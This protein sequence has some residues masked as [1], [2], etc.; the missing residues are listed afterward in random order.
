LTKHRYLLDTNIASCV[1]KGNVPAVDRRLARVPIGNVFISAVI[2]AE[3]RYGVARRPDATRLG[4]LVGDFLLT[5]A[6]LPWDSS[7]A[8][9]Y[10]LLRAVLGRE[11][12]PMG[13]LDMMIG[14]HALAVEAVLVT[15]DRAF[16]RI[17]NLKLAGWTKT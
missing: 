7:A 2:E 4:T 11:G 8:K 1:I 9:Q 13:N 10:G 3:L 17:G 6:I 12:H 16:A 5:V 14:S 15:R